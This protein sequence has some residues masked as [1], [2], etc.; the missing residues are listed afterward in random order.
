MSAWQLPGLA[1]AV[2]KDDRVVYLKGLGVR[3]AGESAPVTPDT[4]FQIASTSKAF[5]TTA[6]AM[7]VDEK[8]M[9]WDDPVRKHLPYF[10]LSD[11]CADA[12]V[13]LRDIVSHRTGV[14]R[15]DDL[16]DYTDWS[17][18]E[19]IRRIAM[20]DLTRPFRASYQYHNIMFMAA[21][22]AVA[23]AAGVPWEEFVATRIFRPLG[24]NNSVVSEAEW[25]RSERAAPHRWDYDTER[26]KRWHTND[27][28]SLGPAGA[29]KS[30][31]RDLAQWVRFQLAGGAIDVKRLISEEALAET[32]KPHAIL[33]PD[34]STAGDTP[35]SHF[36]TYGLGW[37]VQDYRGE[38]LVWHSGSLNSY[39]AQ[40]AFLPQRKAGLVLLTN[41]GRGYGIIA[42]RHALLDLLIG[43]G[44]RD[45]NTHF[46]A[47]ERKLEEEAET[48]KAE[49]EAKRQRGTNPSRE[50]SAY[51]GRYVS[52]I[53]GQAEVRLQEGRLAIEWERLRM[54]LEHYHY[55]TFSTVVEAWD[56]D[57]RVTFDLG[58]D[59]EVR[60]MSLFGQEWQRKNDER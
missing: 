5:T 56:V 3:V 38:P 23:S 22:E 48:K 41:I 51:T 37:R 40:V 36:N 6:M 33:A 44:T 46:L 1:V 2:V 15:H 18:E 7:L 50:L 59:G 10:Q 34:Q 43:K 17:R 58:P 25:M 57:E 26:V 53:Y 39:R 52:P 19:V 60:S 32:W 13:T 11:P 28:S 4:L 12:Q 21:G 45:W 24:M 16:W 30:S 14:A 55:D 47:H 9:S 20:V 31:A 29:I 35:L 54:P 49:R 42:L 8:K 27:Y